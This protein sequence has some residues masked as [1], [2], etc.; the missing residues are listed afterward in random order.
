MNE[1]ELPKKKGTKKVKEEKIEN[2]SN[3]TISE[4]EKNKLIR[5][6]KSKR[7]VNIIFSKL[8]SFIFSILIIGWIAICL[9]D[10]FKV[11]DGKNPIFCLKTETIKLN[12]G[13]IEKCLGAGYKILNFEKDD[14]CHVKLTFGPFWLKDSCP[15]PK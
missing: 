6:E 7:L 4:K 9:I 11:Q 13:S 15:D 2:T 5:K 10:F 8:F 1:E 12:E 14:S 3:E